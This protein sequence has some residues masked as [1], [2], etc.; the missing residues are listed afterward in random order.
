M[1]LFWAREVSAI[2]IKNIRMGEIKLTP[3][4]LKTDPKK[5]QNS[6]VRRLSAEYGLDEGLVKSILFCENGF[7]GI[8]N[9]NINYDKE[10]G[11]EWSRDVGYW[12][13]NN[14]YHEKAAI[15]MGLNIHDDWGNIEY[16]FWLMSTQGTWPWNAS[17]ACW[18]KLPMTAESDV[19]QLKK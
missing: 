16:G 4:P 12:Q 7:Y 13:I 3:I 2:I 15:E 14:Y 17:K 6:E 8:G 18:I 1:A 11:L 5:T 10:T 9:D 19:N